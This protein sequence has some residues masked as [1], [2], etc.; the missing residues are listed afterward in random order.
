M[1]TSRWLALVWVLGLKP[2]CL[3]RRRSTLSVIGIALGITLLFS[4]SLSIS[5][6]RE[7]I[8]Q[9]GSFMNSAD[10]EV[11][12]YYS[13]PFPDIVYAGLLDTGG[14]VIIP[15]VSG[16]GEVSTES[17]G[18]QIP[19]IGAD[20]VKIP[21]FLENFG[22]EDVLPEPAAIFEAR[23][24]LLTAGLAA[25]LKLKPGD[26][27]DIS[28][29]QVRNS[30]RL[31][32]I[33]SGEGLASDAVLMDIAG[34]REILG[35]HGLLD[36]L[37][38]RIKPGFNPD[39]VLGEIA[40][41]LPPDLYL[42]RPEDRILR[43]RDVIRSFDYN[44]RALSLMALLIGM[45]L[46]YNTIFIS[47][48][49]RRREIGI[50]R[51]LGMR[52]VEVMGL[53][54][55]EALVI[56]MLGSAAGVLLGKMVASISDQ[57]VSATLRSLYSVPLMAEPAGFLSEALVPFLFGV[58]ASAVSSLPPSFEAARIA[59][60]ESVREG[61]YESRHRQDYG[62]RALIG[63][64]LIAAGLVVA[65]KIR[66][67]HFP[68]AGFFGVLVMTA[69]F[70]ISAAWFVRRLAAGASGMMWRRYGFGGFMAGANL[71]GAAGRTSTAVSA[72]AVSLACTLGILMLTSSFRTTVEEWVD[73]NLSADLY[74]KDASCSGRVFCDKSLPV[75]VIK[76]LMELQGVRD[77][78]AFR[79]FDFELRG[80]KT[81]IGVSD[82]RLLHKYG[83]LRYKSGKDPDTIL[84]EML[85]GYNTIISEPFSYRFGLK[86][87]DKIA[88][89][90]DKGVIDFTIS[91]VFFDYSSELGYMIIDRRFL[92]P[93]FGRDDAH[94]L[95]IY[96][97]PALDESA[98]VER[99]AKALSDR[100]VVLFKGDELK[101]TVLKIFDRTFL[102][103]RG[104]YMIS[105]IIAL[106]G[107]MNTL[108]TLIM[109]RRKELSILRYLG[110][111]R[112]QTRL[113][114]YLETGLIALAGS[115]MGLVMGL[116]L[117]MI[118]IYV[119]NRQS[120]G[121][122]VDLHMPGLSMLAMLTGMICVT[123]FSAWFPFREAMD[124]RPYR[125]ISEE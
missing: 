34:A 83:R 52:R 115:V 79:G 84:K 93:L 88:V 123:V 77:V 22:Y 99:V 125:H 91:G 62:R 74:V 25:G 23:S 124:I 103:T 1:R 36:S 24:V 72:V 38:I 94:T 106:L 113:M 107:V 66:I 18:R 85:Q 111:D 11:V 54:V 69:G 110:M 81:H 98:M 27:F 120:F 114:I 101:K 17:G 39:S 46:V 53:F 122:T 5:R 116:G 118:L 4:V 95:G 108:F 61:S 9:S 70:V 121:W 100:H 3:D 59:P 32:G 60:A 82:V 109:E 44:L 87:G 47:V 28:L 7:G 30:F 20:V 6:A 40:S 71:S 55:F 64:I 102:V 57:G 29:G 35:K 68:F 76:R 96:F 49:R 92:R 16:V 65:W 97:D 117:G 10:R 119:I 19:V 21:Y 89:P 78:Y 14:V 63:L 31:A 75:T 56:G 80:R 43:T 73:R 41:R 42:R 26:R 104:I 15:V 90:T 33:V 105:L 2:L 58:A 50:L 48:A 51:A 12:S 112:S 8:R 45:F 37:Q 67:T 13:R 86:E